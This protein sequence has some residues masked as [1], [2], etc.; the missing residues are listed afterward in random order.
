MY[1]LSNSG[2]DEMRNYRK[3]QKQQDGEQYHANG[4][5]FWEIPH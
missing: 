4:E 2:S 3:E 5:Q 1:D